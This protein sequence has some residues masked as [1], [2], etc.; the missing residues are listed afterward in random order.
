MPDVFPF[1]SGIGNIFGNQGVVEVEHHVL[2]GLFLLDFGHIDLVDA[3]VRI[4]R[5]HR[6]VS[7]RLSRND[8]G[9]D[10]P[11]HV[12]GIS[13]AR[14]AASRGDQIVVTGADQD[15]VGHFVEE[16][17]AFEVADGADGILKMAVGIGFTKRV[18][19]LDA[20]GRPQLGPSLAA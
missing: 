7:G 3:A 6:G 20:A 9:R 8:G 18:I 10:D 16:I 14:G 13:F 12:P 1:F 2:F 15:A 4:E 11:D 17:S 5:D 19:P